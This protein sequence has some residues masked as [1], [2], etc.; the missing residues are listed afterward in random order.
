MKWI[1]LEKS[2]QILF[3]LSWQSFC[4]GDYPIAA[5]I[6]DREGTVLAFGRNHTNN[7]NKFPNPKV[8]HAETQC[9]QSLDTKRY[10]KVNEY[11]LYTTMEPC[12]MCMGMIVMGGIRHVI[13]GSKDRYAGASDILLTNEYCKSKQVKVELNDAVFG[14]L[15]IAMQGYVELRDRGYDSLVLKRLEQDYPIGAL[16]AKELFEKRMLEEF[17]K[18]EQSIEVIFDTLCDYINCKQ[19]QLATKR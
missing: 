19:V 18:K 10:P 3:G 12:P 5:I 9:L 2:W 16:V 14:D 13:M 17:V 8:V 11:I 7:K 6:V 4:E 1:E 15:Q